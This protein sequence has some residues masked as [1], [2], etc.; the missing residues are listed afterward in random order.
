MLPS[1]FNMRDLYRFD[2]TPNHWLAYD[3]QDV[4]SPY[5]YLKEFLQNHPHITG[6]KFENVGHER[7]IKDERVIKGIAEV[8][9]GH[10][11]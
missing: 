10:F 6:A 3:E 8:I 7:M 4:I 1:D 2:N 11:S 9:K 5:P